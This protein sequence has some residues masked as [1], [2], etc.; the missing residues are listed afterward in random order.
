MKTLGILGDFLGF[1]MAKK[2]PKGTRSVNGSI[3]LLPNRGFSV[4]GLFDRQMALGDCLW[5]F[6]LRFSKIFSRVFFCFSG[7]KLN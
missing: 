1:Q 2:S 7:I 4:P 5:Y 6:F 3:F